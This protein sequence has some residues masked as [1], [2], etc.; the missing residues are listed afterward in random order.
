MEEEITIDKL[1]N[2]LE[3]PTRRK[4]LSKLTKE[5]HYSLQLSREL[6]VSQQAIVKHLKILEDNDHVKSFEEKSTEGGPPRKCYVPR[7]QFSLRIDLG[8]NTFSTEMQ[9]LDKEEDERGKLEKY[10]KLEM[11]LL[12]VSENEKP[13]ERLSQLSNLLMEINNKIEEIEDER[14]ELIRLKERT[15]RESHMIVNALCNDYA[16]R[17]ILYCL[18]DEPSISRLNISERFDLREKVVN[19]IFM[20]LLRNH[21]IPRNKYK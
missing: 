9:V 16:Q 11:E 21:L 8:L 17:K 6:N 14:T 15:L 5:T 18:I 20:E 19:D 3:N 10:Q 4:I 2:I 1:L 7:H 12:D 13:R